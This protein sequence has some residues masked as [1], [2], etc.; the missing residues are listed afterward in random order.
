LITAPLIGAFS[1]KD[2][3]GANLA[4]GFSY[5]RK[6]FGMIADA[7]LPNFD[8]CLFFLVVNLMTSRLSRL[9]SNYRWME[10]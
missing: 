1:G 6:S 8:Q 4:L 9:Q 3:D 7:H 5:L 10:K 2:I